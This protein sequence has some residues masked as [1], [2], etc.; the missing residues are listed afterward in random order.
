MDL[1]EAWR[2]PLQVTPWQPAVPRLEHPETS[3]AGSPAHP[4]GPAGWPGYVPPL[5]NP[6]S[7]LRSGTWPAAQGRRAPRP[8]RMSDASSSGD[9]DWETL[10]LPVN[11]LLP[12]KL[13]KGHRRERHLLAE[14]RKF[15][16]FWEQWK[17]RHTEAHLPAA[18]ARP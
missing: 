3:A 1:V 8:R 7:A 5:Q 15:E 11:G 14:E 9:E 17:A 18:D 2:H 4:G 6:K 16:A 13:E 12:P 10:D